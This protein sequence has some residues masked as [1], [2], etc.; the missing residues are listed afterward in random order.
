MLQAESRAEDPLRLSTT[1]LARGSAT[2]KSP[3]SPRTPRKGVPNVPPP[4][5]DQVAVLPNSPNTKKLI[6]VGNSQFLYG[7]QIGE[8][9][10]ST[11]LYLSGDKEGLRRQLD[12][13]GFI[14]VRGVID[15]TKA[16]KCRMALLNHLAA[17]NAF[18]PGTPINDAIIRDPKQ[19]GWT[20]DAETGGYV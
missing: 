12:K 6:Q 1:G 8:M 15:K 14:F 16:T 10:D 9:T 19:S 3:K 13:E 4:N 11:H 7:R 18:E 5:L 17:K 20:V 2:P